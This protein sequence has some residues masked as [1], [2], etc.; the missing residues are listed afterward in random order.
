MKSITDDDPATKDSERAAMRVIVYIINLMIFA[1]PFYAYFADPARRHR[2]RLRV[3]ASWR[4]C[5]PPA[6]RRAS[7]PPCLSSA[8]LR[9]CPPRVCLLCAAPTS[10]A[11][12]ASTGIVVATPMPMLLLLHA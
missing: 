2:F 5:V 7:A 10:G 9:P 8:C 1:L 4:R 11:E 6:C 3:S 12:H